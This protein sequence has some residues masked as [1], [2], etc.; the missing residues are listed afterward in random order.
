MIFQIIDDKK[1][2]IGWFANGKLR[3]GSLPENMTATWDWSPRLGDQRVALAKIYAK[4]KSLADIVPPHLEGRWTSRH[5]K[6]TSH[7]K[8]FVNAGVKMSDICFYEL[9]PSQDIKHYYQTLNEITE[10]VVDNV[11]RPSNYSFL[12]DLTI[13]CREIAQQEVKIDWPLLKRFAN[14]DQKAMYLAKSCWDRKNVVNYNPFGTV[15]GRLGLN[16][17]SF[18]ILNLKKEIRSCVVPQNDLFIELDFNGAELRTLLHLS[19]HPQPQEDIH[20]WNQRNLFT[21]DITRDDAK[22]KIFAWLYNP[23]SRVIDSDYYDKT[24]VLEKHYGDGVVTTPF[25]RR[26][27]SDDFHALNYLIQSTSSDNFLTNANKIHRYLRGMKSNVAFLVHDSLV[28]DLHASEKHELSNIIR[29]FQDT[30]L[31]HFKTNVKIG[32]NLGKM[33]SVEW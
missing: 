28:I 2:C 20:D 12:H 21:G 22:R 4:G 6:M 33:E 10:W 11:D 16:E 15:T 23:T 19:G 5:R 14:K 7:I 29:L 9:I 31:G 8:S 1:E 13:T 25:R 18:P 26:I 27:E 32:K 30:T 3:A 24:K 17:G